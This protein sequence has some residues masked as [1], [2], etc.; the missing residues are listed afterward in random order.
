[1]LSKTPTG[2]DSI[3]VV[4]DRFTKSAH[5]IPMKVK[6]PMDKWGSNI[7]YL[8]L[9]RTHP[10]SNDEHLVATSILNQLWPQ[11]LSLIDVALIQG[12]LTLTSINA[13]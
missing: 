2:E 11:C 12:R 5:F 13:S 1:M 9:I 6:D 10:F 4:G 8:A 7:Q 3:L